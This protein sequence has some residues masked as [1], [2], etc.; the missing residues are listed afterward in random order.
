MKLVR[1]LNGWLIVA[2]L[3]TSGVFITVLWFFPVPSLSEH[4][5][6]FLLASAAIYFTACLT[7]NQMVLQALDHVRQSQVV[8]KIGKPLLLIA[9]IGLFHLSTIP[10]DAKGLVILTSIVL[11]ICSIWLLILVVRQLRPFQRKTAPPETSAITWSR[12]SFYFFC[13][14]LLNLLS[15]RIVMLLLPY[16]TSSERTVGILNICTRFADLLIFPFFLMHTVLPQL[17]ARHSP[18]EQ[19]Y[20]QK[21]FTTS[22]RL[23]SLLCLPLLLI[24]ILAGKYLL[25]WFGPEFTDGYAALVYIS[26][27]QFLFSFFGPSNTILMTQGHER[28]SAFCLLGYVLVLVIACCVLLPIAGITGGALAM[29]ISSLFY[30]GLLAVVNY[31]T[32]GIISPFFS[33]LVRRR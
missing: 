25:S 3:I 2:A 31:R 23:M 30:N 9:C 29:L 7:L 14:S 15:T 11:L 8:E 5:A 13:I 27:A 1:S 18:E 22:I 10:F 26:L 21:L 4:K 12:S 16:F 6:L 20:T 24:N 19:P 28:S 17:F 32:T 33:F